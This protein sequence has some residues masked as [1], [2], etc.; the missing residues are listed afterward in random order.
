MDPINPGTAI[1][2]VLLLNRVSSLAR[3]IARRLVARHS[4]DDVAHD[5]V[6]DCLVR[7]RTGQ[8]RVGTTLEQ[9][10]GGM[11]RNKSLDARRRA[12]H[13]RALGPQYGAERDEAPPSWMQPDA[14][15]EER[16]NEIRLR[17]ALGELPAQCRAA[18][19]LVRT[20][21]ATYRE[22]AKQLGIS[23]GLLAK[24]VR[25]AERHLAARLLGRRGWND[26]PPSVLRRRPRRR[27]TRR[28][29]VPTTPS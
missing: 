23:V 25:N 1:D 19:V 17:R 13:R 3:R 15:L 4:A 10:V 2:E 20:E 28:S 6:L 26:T 5:V 7:L 11:V 29:R 16:E 18:F 14:L 27:R 8:W 12:A 21:E 22:A 9:L 24:H